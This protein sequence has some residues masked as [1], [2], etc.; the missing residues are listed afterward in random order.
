MT[1]SVRVQWGI[2]AYGL[3]LSKL[4]RAQRLSE[5][6]DS[7]SPR[8]VAEWFEGRDTTGKAFFEATERHLGHSSSKPLA[9]RPNMEVFVGWLAYRFANADDAL[10]FKLTFGGEA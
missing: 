3:D 9:S 7:K 4:Q 10:L 1:Y 8:A 5:W 6:L 2:I